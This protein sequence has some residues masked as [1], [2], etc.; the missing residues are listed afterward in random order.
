MSLSRW[1]GYLPNQ[2]EWH[3]LVTSRE[4]IERFDLK[5]LGF[6]S[7]DDA[8]RLFL[9]HYTRDKIDTREVRDL[10]I[11]L[12]FHTLTI[13][14]LAKTAQ[15]QRTGPNE[16][17][18]AIKNDLKANVYVQHKGDKIERVTSYLCSI[19]VLNE[20]KKDELRLLKQFAC[21]PPEFHSYELLEGLT[22]M[23]YNPGDS[24]FPEIL[25]T[26]Q[27]KG[28]CCKTR[29]PIAIKCTA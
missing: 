23:Q 15:L 10:V 1:Y 13:E 28:G 21:L 7:G 24:E 2:P 12:D 11:A 29:K 27:A 5:D 6:L 14:I 18:N 16:L 3:V 25:E 4:N 9:S 19:F 22:G 17:M 26:F 8:V 20:L